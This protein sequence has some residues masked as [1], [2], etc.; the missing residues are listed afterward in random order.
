MFPE[1]FKVFA[2][3]ALFVAHCSVV[4]GGCLVPVLKDND[5]N[6]YL[7]WFFALCFGMAV[8]IALLF[9]LGITGFF[10]APTILL[11]AAALLLVAI[12]SFYRSNGAFLRRGAIQKLPPI[13]ILTA[14]SL[15]LLFILTVATA[16]RVPG[17]FDD[18]MYHLPL[19]RSYIEH[20]GIVLQEYL[21]F[22]LF[23]QNMNLL[24]ALGLMFGYEVWAQAFASLPVFVMGLG[25]VGASCYLFRSPNLGLLTAALL[26]MIG[27]IKRML[28]YAYVDN[29]L[30]LFCWAAILAL[31][32]WVSKRKE[33]SALQ[34]LLVAGVMAGIA[35]GIKLF[36]LVLAAFLGL[37]LLIKRD[38]K[39][40]V[41]YGSTFLLF[42]AWWYVRSFIISGDPVHP[43]GGP[44]FGFY[45][46]DAQD[47]AYQKAEQATHGVERNPL[48]IW[49]ALAHVKLWVLAL[50]G[51]LLRNVPAPIRAMQFAFIGYFVFWFFVTQVWRYLAPV[52]VVATFLSCYTAYRVY[53]W[54]TNAVNIRA[55]RAELVLA[56]L[57]TL[58]VAG[59]TYERFANFREMADHW[60][61]KVAERSGYELF[62]AANDFIPE[63][64]ATL[65]Q[66][67]FEHRRYFFDGI[68]IGDWFGPGRYRSMLDCSK[69]GCN[70]LEPQE[71]RSYL[72]KRG[73]GMMIVST[74]QYPDFD[75]TLYEEHFVVLATTEG[76]V[77]LGLR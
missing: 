36:G 49:T 40:C 75:V 28:G 77:L 33:T 12:A 6:I 67:G 42:G 59:Y 15:L 46:W 1:Y 34:W 63:Y 38:L 26:F 57:L 17:Y 19:A 14:V 10:T 58:T 18:T 39:A 48:Y 24:F 32:V 62:Q 8:N 13:H 72:Q 55:R 22:P 7:K 11:S 50:V 25:A 68:V 51:L 54:G 21:R 44:V 74:E 43:A 65:V 45:L 66:L 4:G 27:P 41:V 69:E 47:L 70:V 56:A 29:G 60:V 52:Y 71:M 61:S 73:A 2:F 64:G 5:L 53:A 35:A 31:A 23:P 20:Q 3:M 16:F 37:Y 9:I 30:G 76:G